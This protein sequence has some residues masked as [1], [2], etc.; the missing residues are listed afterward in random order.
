M[1]SWRRHRWL[2]AGLPG[3]L[4]AVLAIASQLALG[5]IVL[6]DEAAAREQSVAALDALSILCNAAAPAAPDQPVHHRH[7]PDCAVCPLSVALAMP[8]AVLGSA[9]EVPAPSSQ[10][11]A[12][13]TLLPPAR[14]PPAQ[15]HRT[16]PSQGPPLL[17]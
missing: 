6:P 8:A 14:G 15:P 13:A 17:S 7:N 9:P 11:A 1:F 4:V 16:P 12:R 10:S 3:L 2:P 5:T